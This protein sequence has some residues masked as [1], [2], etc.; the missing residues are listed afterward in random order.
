MSARVVM[1]WVKVPNK[2]FL[3][4]SRWWFIRVIIEVNGGSNV[5][6]RRVG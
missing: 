4:G 5:L 3:A 2:V 6:V 1:Y